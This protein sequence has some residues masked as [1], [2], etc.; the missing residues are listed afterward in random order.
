M[1]Q[2]SFSLFKINK[3]LISHPLRIVPLAGISNINSLVKLAKKEK[4][5]KKIWKF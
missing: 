2:K 5:K 1:T 3:T 4:K